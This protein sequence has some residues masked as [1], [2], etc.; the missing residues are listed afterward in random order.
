[1]FYDDKTV[2]FFRVYIMP[3]FIADN[4]KNEIFATLTL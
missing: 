4:I 2:F 3:V 1:M